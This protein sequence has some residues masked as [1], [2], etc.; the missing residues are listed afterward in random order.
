MKILLRGAIAAVALVSMGGIAQAQTAQRHYAAP[1]PI[2]GV[3][4]VLTNP[5]LSTIPG[6]IAFGIAEAAVNSGI[7][8]RY[9]A[10]A[11]SLGDS[12]P[13]TPVVDVVFTLK[14]TVN[15]DCSFY[16]GNNANATNIDFGVIGVRTGNNENVG[17][18]FE[19]RAPAVA[20]IQSLTAGCNFNNNVEISKDD[21]RGMVNNSGTGYDTN[22][23][24]ANIPYSV[25]ASW[26]GVALGAVTAGTPQSLT[27]D[28]VSNAGL[29]P[30]GAWRSKMDILITAAVQPKALV[31]GQYNGKTTL[32]LRAL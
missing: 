6:V 3:G 15:K 19:M 18:A 27:V 30:Q 5:D 16:A 24:Q 8:T 9:T 21:I 23:F 32:T 31:A 29:K 2:P 7:G 14:G 26:Q 20:T 25:A 11:A 12:T 28:A 4:V 1:T 17:D 22:E 13:A 10:Y